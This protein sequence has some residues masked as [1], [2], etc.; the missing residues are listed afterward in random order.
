MYSSFWSDTINLGLSIVYIEWAQV[1][2]SK[3]NYCVS[4][5]ED[6]FSLANSV[7]TDE[8]PHGVAFHLSL[9]CLPKY[10]FTSH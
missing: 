1:I 6:I 7:D 3:N 5:A 8:M 10:A 9:H 4:F 2:L